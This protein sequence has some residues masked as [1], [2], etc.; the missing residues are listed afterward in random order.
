MNKP[1][2]RTKS[3][4]HIKEKK[5]QDSKI[6]AIKNER[7]KIRNDLISNANLIFGLDNGSTG[8][9]SCINKV[10]GT[11]SFMKTP[12]RVELDYTQDIKYINRIDVVELKKW[13]E[14]N[15][16]LMKDDNRFII[17][18]L[19]RPMKNPTRFEQS[20][21]ACRA[22]EATL[23]VLEEL[24]LKYIVIDSKQWQH[25]FFG[26]NTTNIDLKLESMRKGLDVLNKNFK[27]QYNEISEIIKNHGD[28]DS[29]LICQ[30]IIDQQLQR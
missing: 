28:A 7:K 24:N 12:S 16:S 10:D 13:F 29:L 22:F 1:I 26:K 19:E 27:K 15:I 14:T 4:L 3:N 18:I 25:Y 5:K 17:V 9:I 30:Y 2:D 11:I 8:T 23:I 6:A 21:S 20:I